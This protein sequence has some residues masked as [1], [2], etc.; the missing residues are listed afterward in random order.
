MGDKY[1]KYVFMDRCYAGEKII[2]K[3][4]SYEYIIDKPDEQY[5][6]YN[7]SKDEYQYFDTYNQIIENGAVEGS[8]LE[9]ILDNIDI[10]FMDFN[11]KKEFITATIMNREIEFEYNGVDYF[12]SCCDEGYYIYNSK[13]KTSQYFESPEK[14]LE[15]G[16]LEGRLMSELW[17]EIYIQCLY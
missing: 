16:R 14:L 1:D 7:K 11:T 8:R 2:F 15:N 9:D 4:H 5:Y 17:D 3:Y 10:I 6:L 12:K 13:E